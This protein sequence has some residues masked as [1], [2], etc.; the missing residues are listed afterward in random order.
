MESNGTPQFLEPISISFPMRLATL[1]FKPTVEIPFRRE[2][3]PF[4]MKILTESARQRA[5]GG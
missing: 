3:R 5:I 1:N 2:L 4:V